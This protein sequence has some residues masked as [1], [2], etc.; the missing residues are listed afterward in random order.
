MKFCVLL[1]GGVLGLDAFS[2]SSRVC[3]GC[4]VIVMTSIESV[5]PACFPSI[6]LLQIWRIFNREV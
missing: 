5:S 1:A 2:M 6:N 3:S 4:S